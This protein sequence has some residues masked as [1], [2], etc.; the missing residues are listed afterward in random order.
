MQ[1]AQPGYP[2]PTGAWSVTLRFYEGLEPDHRFTIQAACYSAPGV[3]QFEYPPALF[4][5]QRPA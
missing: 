4:T 5:L 2:D 3:K 1:G